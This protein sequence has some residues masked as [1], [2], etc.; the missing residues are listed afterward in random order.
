[1]TESGAAGGSRTMLPLLLA[2]LFLACVLAA[3][4]FLRSERAELVRETQAL[5]SAR[6]SVPLLLDSLGRRR[7]EARAT[8]ALEQARAAARDEPTLHL[9][10]AVD[11]GTVALVR[12]G[13]TLRSMP[14]R[15]RGAAPARGTQ[16]IVKIAESPVRI[17]APT[18]D[19]LGN[20]VAIAASETRV[21]RVTLS[22]GTVMEGGDAADVLLGGIDRV[23]GPRMIVVSRRDFAA[24][25]PNLVR[26][27]KA[28]LF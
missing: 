4:P 15:F 26:G 20:T 5:S 13:I 21:E 2:G 18:V 8:L 9:V 24:V 3:V 6:A 19:S 11:S 10:I 17:E 12:D 27:M 14:A 7:A 16:T 28:V 22:D 25:R 23:P 1:M